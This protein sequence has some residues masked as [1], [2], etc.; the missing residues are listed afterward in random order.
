MYFDKIL[1]KVYD[2]I[3]LLHGSA[4]PVGTEIAGERISYANRGSE[5]RLDCSIT[6]GALLPLYYVTWRSASDHSVIF[7]QIF[8]PLSS[9]Q[10]PPDILDNRYR[11]D[12]RNFSL[13]V[14]NV[15]LADAAHGYQCVLGVVDPRDDQAYDY[16]ATQNV[17]ISLSIFSKY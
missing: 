5:G 1:G 8:P 6:P 15:E 17:N 10:P 16:T 3:P 11:I 9:R 14:S 12:S 7:Y 4:R 13:F 2:F